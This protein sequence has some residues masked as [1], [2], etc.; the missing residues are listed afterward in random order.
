MP[1]ND[2]VYAGHMLDSS[3]RAVAKLAGKERAEFDS[4][5]TL[6]LAAVHLVQIVGEAARMVSVEFRQ[7]HPEIPWS[8]ITG[9]R[10]RIVHE[11]FDYSGSIN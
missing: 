4:D 5:D 3:R 1:K 8:E 11:Y 10:H 7:Q 6:Q 2:L 9:M